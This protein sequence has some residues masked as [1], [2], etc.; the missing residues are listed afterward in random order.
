MQEV[1]SSVRP[2]VRFG[3]FDLDLRSGELRKS[4]VR[5][6]L[7]DQPFR[8][9]AVLLEHPGELV[10]RDELRSRVWPA[11]TFVD[12]EHGLNAGIKRLR[13]ALGDSA[14]HPRYIET[15]PKR[16][17]RFIA[18][19]DGG[20]TAPVGAVELETGPQ[21]STRVAR[22][23]AHG[24]GIDTRDR[25]EIAAGVR[26]D[27]HVDQPAPGGGQSVGVVAGWAVVARDRV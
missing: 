22:H 6:K 24:F 3:V 21:L 1:S 12:F 7:A 15:V 4:G 19:I 5:V 10:T 20:P 25:C 23:A 18:P 16:G 11:D 9:L 8:V 2:I 13:D 27:F 14:E 17:Y 26:N